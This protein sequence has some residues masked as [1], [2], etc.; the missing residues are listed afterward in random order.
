[1]LSVYSTF[2]D[3][4]ENPVGEVTRLF[5]EHFHDKLAPSNVYGNRV[6]DPK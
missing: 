5:Y 1:M 3:N 4:E 2:L 6:R